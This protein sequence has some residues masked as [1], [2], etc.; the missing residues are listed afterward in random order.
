MTDWKLTRQY[1][2]V[3]AVQ[4]GEKCAFSEGVLTVNEEELVALTRHLFKAV[5]G[6][7]LEITSPGENARIVHVLDAIAPMVKVEGESQ[8][9]PGIFST[10]YTAGQGVT[11]LYR[12]FS[13]IESA[14][15]PW[16]SANASSGLLYPRD[17]IIELSGFAAGYTP[18]AV[19]YTHL[20]LP[21]KA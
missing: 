20:T 14:A 4:F 1:Y 11:N 7:H 21:T 8:Q 15:L 17:A 13:I 2:D 18:F 9:Y 5:T 16:D 12:G 10:P 19:S 3:K 6:F